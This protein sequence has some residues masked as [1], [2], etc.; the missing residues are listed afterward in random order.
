MTMDATIIRLEQSD[1][2][3]I[4]VLRLDGQAF[5]CT[6]EPPDNGNQKNIS[7]IPPGV[8]TALRVVSPKYGD[9]FEIT[10]VPNRSHV[11]FHAGNVVKHTK[12]CVLVGQYFGKLKGNRA[13]LNSGKT[14]A[15]FL[16]KIGPL[17]AFTLEI[18]EAF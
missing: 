18:K 9:T 2:G 5:A 11:L 3:T 8:Y 4:G 13:V 15:S 14:F 17:S 7:C 16:A 10:K 12:G 6:L 1:Q